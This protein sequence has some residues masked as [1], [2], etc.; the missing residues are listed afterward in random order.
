MTQRERSEDRPDLLAVLRLLPLGT[1]TGGVMKLA[2]NGFSTYTVA[3][4]LGDARMTSKKNSSAH[5]GKGEPSQTSVA[6]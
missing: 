2:R 6:L 4:G 5:G 1:D 3:D